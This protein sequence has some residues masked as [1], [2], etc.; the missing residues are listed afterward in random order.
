M[1]CPTIN[2]IW[3]GM[4]KKNKGITFSEDKNKNKKTVLRVHFR[5]ILLP[6]SKMHMS[7]G[8]REPGENN[9]V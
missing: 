9:F 2:R 5:R 6:V 3:R 8:K 1:G 4:I 7:Y